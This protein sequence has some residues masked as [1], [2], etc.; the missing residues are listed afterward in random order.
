MNLKILAPPLLNNPEGCN[1]NEVRDALRNMAMWRPDEQEMW[2][3]YAKEVMLPSS[4]EG[5][6]HVFALTHNRAV[7][8]M[9]WAKCLDFWFPREFFDTLT[10]PQLLIDPTHL[11]VFSADVASTYAVIY[12]H[13]HDPADQEIVELY[14]LLQSIAENLGEDK[15]HY[16]AYYS[17]D[18]EELAFIGDILN[19]YNDTMLELYEREKLRAHEKRQ[20]GRT[21]SS[22]RQGKA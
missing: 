21:L 9:V 4:T 18:P 14:E 8:A 7:F 16:L 12:A 13:T 20:F 22:Y 2:L 3:R 15:L 17:E 5:D 6:V 10:S 1:R 19:R 11:A